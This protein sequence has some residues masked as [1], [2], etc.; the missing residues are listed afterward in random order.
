MPHQGCPIAAAAIQ[1]NKPNGKLNV[2]AVPKCPLGREKRVDFIHR[3]WC[4]SDEAKLEL[5]TM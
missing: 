4:L 3:T 1:P 2:N 5:M